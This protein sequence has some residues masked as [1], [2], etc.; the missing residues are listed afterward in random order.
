MQPFKKMLVDLLS[1]RMRPGDFEMAFMSRW[2]EDD[3]SWMP[4]DVFR[5]MEDFFFVVEN[6]VDNPALRDPASGDLGPEEL[7]E[8]ARELLRRAGFE[9]PGET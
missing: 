1:D 6:Y 5:A 3:D 7:K 9:V 2:G 4:D 8:R